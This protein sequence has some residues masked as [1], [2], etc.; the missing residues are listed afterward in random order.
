MGVASSMI[1]DDKVLVLCQERKRF[2][3]E[4]LDGRCALACAHHD[5]IVSLRDTGSLLRNCFE[6]EKSP[7]AA[8]KEGHVA[9]SED[10]FDNP[11]TETVAQAQFFFAAAH[12]S[13]A[14]K[15]LAT[16]LVCCREEVSIPKPPPQAEIKYL[17]WHRSVSSQLSPSKN[18][19]GTILVVHTSTLDRLYAWETKL[20]DEVKLRGL[21][22]FGNAKCDS[23]FR[24]VAP[25]AGSM[26]RNL[27]ELI[28]SLTMIWATMLQCHRHQH[29]IIKSL[30]SSCKL[31]IPFD[32]D[33]HCQTVA[34]LSAELG[35]LRLNLQ[36]WISSHKAYLRSINLWLHKCMKPLRKR[37]S[38][39]KQNA[40]AV[41][42][43]LA[44]CA[45]APMFA[46]GETWM[47][48]LDD[49]PT[50]DL[51][52]AIECLVAGISRLLP[53]RLDQ[54]L[55]ETVKDGEAEQEVPR[56]D[57]AADLRSI[58]V[59]FVD[60]LEA[61]SEVS[62]QKYLDLQRGV[63]AAKDRLVREA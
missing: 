14:S 19:P 1:E 2:V 42:V 41:D 36:N 10:G 29:G 20:Y 56:D 33:S 11:S 46:A 15:F 28:E 32:S 57:A 30:S 13:K 40:A 52:E 43:S 17:T 22:P 39:R 62:V 34:L 45:V 61:F 59:V 21:L 18:P 53:R 27:D 48:L 47:K 5:Y 26:M 31:Q 38:S 54:R 51:E 60:K 58:L 3:R 12:E 55:D 35:K 44:E 37:K 25:S 50:E 24:P 23:A 6:G 49:L 63:G 16:F 8:N 4:A 9:D 7:A